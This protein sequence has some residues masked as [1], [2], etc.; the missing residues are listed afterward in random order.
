MTASQRPPSGP[1]H[2]E[3]LDDLQLAA[4][5]LDT[6]D[7]SFDLSDQEG[8]HGRV[9]HVSGLELRL[10]DLETFGGDDLEEIEALAPGS[11]QPAASSAPESEKGAPEGV[12]PDT[13]KRALAGDGLM[14]D[15][16]FSSQWQMNSEEWDEVATKIDLARAYVEMED[17]D[18]AR[19][20]L[21][22][23]AEEGNEEQRAE[24]RE[25]LA[26]LA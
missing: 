10:E 7:E 9:A 5:G 3:R 23:V 20:I 15:D 12:T 6:F 17:P 25:M 26:R 24:A 13:A 22:E 19:S 4:G 21:E 1:A 16:T 14:P 18:A 11:S 2:S 8:A